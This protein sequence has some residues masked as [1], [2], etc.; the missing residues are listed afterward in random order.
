MQDLPLNWC[1]T[2]AQALA[3]YQEE[4]KDVQDFAYAATTFRMF[5]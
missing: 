4:G 1:V 3:A 5:N 2:N